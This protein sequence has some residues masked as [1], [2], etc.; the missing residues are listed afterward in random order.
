MRAESVWRKIA[1]CARTSH[2]DPP[3]TP[4]VRAGPGAPCGPGRRATA[5]LG[6]LGLALSRAGGGNQDTKRTT[7]KKDENIMAA[8]TAPSRPRHRCTL[9]DSKRRSRVGHGQSRKQWLLSLN[10]SLN[11][12]ERR[13]GAPPDPHSRGV[14]EKRRRAKNGRSALLLGLAVVNVAD[15]AWG[16]EGAWANQHAR[17]PPTPPPPAGNLPPC[18]LP[19]SFPPLPPL[20]SAP[21]S[22]GRLA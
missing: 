10:S 20:A 3:R 16:R 8:R 5:L 17:R 21:S 4:A 7:N 9:S 15:G 1:E 18:F 6:A 13:P 19:Y 12:L 22:V 2:R 11:G 14:A